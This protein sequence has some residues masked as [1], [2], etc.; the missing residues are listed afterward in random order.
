MVTRSSDRS[1]CCS[2]CDRRGACCPGNDWTSGLNNV[3]YLDDR[4]IRLGCS[5]LVI[6]EL[7]QVRLLEQLDNQPGVAE[8]ERRP[9][10]DCC[11]FFR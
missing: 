5:W 9:L 7:H 11:D 1:R 4:F 10:D 6:G 8:V 2:M 3:A